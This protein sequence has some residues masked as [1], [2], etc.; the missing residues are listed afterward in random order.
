M[1]QRAE[2][3]DVERFCQ[4]ISPSAEP[5]TFPA[6]VHCTTCGKWFC[7]PHAEDDERHSCMLQDKDEGGEA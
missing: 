4:G 1:E 7:D 5:C 2:N 6:T 3:E